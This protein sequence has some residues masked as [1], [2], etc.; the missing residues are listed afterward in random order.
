MGVTLSNV[1]PANPEEAKHMQPRVIE[2]LHAIAHAIQ[3]QRVLVDMHMRNYLQRPT[4][5]ID[6]PG[7]ANKLLQWTQL[8]TSWEVKLSITEI[9]ALLGQLIDR[10][11]VVFSNQPLHKQGF[12]VGIYIL[13]IPRSRYFPYRSS[14]PPKKPNQS[15]NL[16]FL[17]LGLIRGVNRQ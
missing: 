2:L 4:A 17:S 7:M 11:E 10:C 1:V 6:C 14:P 15:I 5:R 13:K 12:V 3:S 8:V 9:E 16:H